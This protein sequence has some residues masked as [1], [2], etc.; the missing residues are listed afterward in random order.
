[1]YLSQIQIMYHRYTNCGRTMI[2]TLGYEVIDMLLKLDQFILLTKIPI[3]KC[4]PR[5]VT[6]K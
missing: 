2:L 3:S 5:I 4:I 1:M 6:K